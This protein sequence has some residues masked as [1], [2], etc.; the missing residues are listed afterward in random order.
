MRHFVFCAGNFPENQAAIDNA[1]KAAEILRREWIGNAC[2]TGIYDGS[3]IIINRDD[4]NNTSVCME[5][6]DI[7]RLISSCM[8]FTREITKLKY[9]HTQ[10]C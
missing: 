6:E 9:K 3:E 7:H 5:D 8:D 2:V 10:L 4:G 1:L